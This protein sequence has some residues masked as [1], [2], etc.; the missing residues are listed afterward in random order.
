VVYRGDFGLLRGL[1]YVLVLLVEQ[2]MSGYERFGSRNGSLGAESHAQ[3]WGSSWELDLLPKVPRSQTY[4]TVRAP[5]KALPIS[6]G[7]LTDEFSNS[8][9]CHLPVAEN[10]TGLVG[11]QEQ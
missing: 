7:A 8:T 1:L 9:V 11:Y 10:Y 2:V 5:P 6:P 3:S 4:R